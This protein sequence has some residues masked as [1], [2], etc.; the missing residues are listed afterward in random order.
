MRK[1]TVSENMTV[2]ALFFGM[3]LLDAFASGA[4]LRAAFWLFIAA[5]FAGAAWLGGRPKE[6]RRPVPHLRGRRHV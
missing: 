5:V 2:F 1:L 3:S 6:P 4:L